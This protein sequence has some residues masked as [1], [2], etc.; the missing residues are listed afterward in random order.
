[1]SLK[2]LFTVHLGLRVYVIPFLQSVNT[3]LFIWKGRF[4]YLHEILFQDFLL[5]SILG[6][7]DN[8]GHWNSWLKCSWRCL[9][10]SQFLSI[11][12]SCSFHLKVLM[13]VQ[14][15]ILCLLFFR[16]FTCVTWKRTSMFR[17]NLLF[18]NVKLM[19][20]TYPERKT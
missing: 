9:V 19:T 11:P 6:A 10:L 15:V 3:F 18:T 8:K 17:L 14:W 13:G 1:M 4:H 16:T 7:T 12:P 5:K 20:H 2:W